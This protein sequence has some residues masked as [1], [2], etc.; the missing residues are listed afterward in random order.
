M[1]FSYYMYSCPI[2]IK[3]LLIASIFTSFYAGVNTMFEKDLKK[4]I[5]LSTLRHLGFICISFSCGLVYLRFFHLLVHAL[6]KSLLFMSIGDIII[7]LNHSQ[8]IRYL[9]SGF[10]Y[11][12]LSCFIMNVSILNLIGIPS[13]RGFFS[14]DLILELLNYSS[15]RVFVVFVI[16]LNVFFTFYYTYQFFFYSFQRSKVNPY[17]LFHSIGVLHSSIL[18]VL[19][20][21]TFNFSYIFFN[22]IY[23]S[24]SFIPL[25]LSFKLIPLVLNCL[26]FLGFY[27]LLR[28]PTINTKL[29]TSF[30]SSMIF[31]HFIAIS[32]SSGVFFSL[33]NVYTKTT[34]SGL[35]NY[36]LN[37]IPKFL[38]SHSSGVV[39]KSLYFIQYNFIRLSI[40]FLFLYLLLQTI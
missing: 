34:E 2:L 9:S 11:T 20:V 17:Q 23:F 21:F 18:L 24:I 39:V 16:Y 38:L 31:L 6:F 12:P 8:D 30:F 5:A 14:K 36:S 7:N 25:I 33:G 32:V 13:L 4:I 27:S 1:R 22:F 3:I 35:Y 15:R 29:T 10:T 28:S 37:V 40:L 26:F 19:S